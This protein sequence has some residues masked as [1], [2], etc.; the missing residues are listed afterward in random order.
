MQSKRY[1]SL[2]SGKMKGITPDRDCADSLFFFSKNKNNCCSI[3]LKNVCTESAISLLFVWKK[4]KQHVLIQ[5]KL[6]K[7]SESADKCLYQRSFSFSVCQKQIATSTGSVQNNLAANHKQMI[8]SMFTSRLLHQHRSLQHPHHDRVA[9]KFWKSLTL[10]Y[11]WAQVVSF[12]CSGNSVIELLTCSQIG[13][14]TDLTMPRWTKSAIDPKRQKIFRDCW[15][16][17]L[18]PLAFC[19]WRL[20]LNQ[21]TT[22]H[23]KCAV[24]KGWLWPGHAFLVRRRK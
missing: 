19:R 20:C 5:S 12:G 18:T 4:Q 24:V 22:E 1:E 23:R 10:C 14:Q 2:W 21:M 6:C 15:A 8:P 3:R 9:R 7:V 16:S 17:L 13:V 11:L